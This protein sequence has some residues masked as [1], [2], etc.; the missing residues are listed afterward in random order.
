MTAPNDFSC[1]T[2]IL[3]INV[4]CFP[5]CCNYAVDFLF[6]MSYNRSTW[7]VSGRNFDNETCRKTS[8]CSQ[9]FGFLH[10]WAAVDDDNGI[11]SLRRF[12]IRNNQVLTSINQKLFIFIIQL[13]YLR[14]V[15][16]KHES[17][18]SKLNNNTINFNNNNS[19]TMKNSTS[20]HSQL[21]GPLGRYL[22]ILHSH[23]TWV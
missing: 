12:G 6:R 1:L 7:R 20:N 8:E 16:S 19:G 10:A 17:T 9:A 14:T 23:S 13:K 21:L 18:L 3:L 4:D 15:R 11:C 22:D 2:R 5:I